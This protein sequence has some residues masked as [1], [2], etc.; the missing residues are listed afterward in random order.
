[1]VKNIIFTVFSL[2][3]LIGLLGGIKAIQFK[4]LFAAAATMVP[5]PAA[6][7]THKVEQQSWE[8]TLKAIGSLEATQ[9]VVISADI[10]GRITDIFFTPGA[11]VEK[12]TPL[13]QQDI[14]SETTQLRAAEANVELAR[15]NVERVRELYNKR[16]SSKADLDTAEARYKEAL[17]QADTFRAAIE[18]KT[19]KA[20]FSGRLGIRLVNLGQDLASGTPIV[21]LQAVDTMFLNFS[22]PQQS[23][24]FLAPG[25]PVRMT[26][27]AVPGQ[28]YEGVITTID[29]EVDPATRNVR[30]QATVE[31]PNRKLLPG[32]FSNVEVVLP[33][34]EPVVAVPITAVSYA[35]YG[36][37]VFVVEEQTN[38]AGEIQLIAR[39]QFV[40]LGRTQGDFVVVTKGINVD[41]TVVI[42]GGFKLQNGA[43]V[44]VNND[45]KPAFSLNP[46]P[47]DT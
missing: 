5:P 18:K 28:I 20:P 21:S 42:S 23:L 16:A 29:P 9:G 25:L 34:T 1:M 17:A 47:K 35:T 31:N 38:E 30:V 3:A 24:A 8:I 43:P 11:Q 13:I 7:A 40:Q 39:Q 36:D 19:V 4:D 6:V 15:L 33:E 44:T 32:M 45:V 37:S 2:F 46:S 14:S 10:P 12:G 26:T 27:D 22:L 41:D